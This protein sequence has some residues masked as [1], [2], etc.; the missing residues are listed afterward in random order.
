MKIVEVHIGEL[1]YKKMILNVKIYRKEIEMKRKIDKTI[2]VF[3][4]LGMIF[5]QL[6]SPLTVF[7]EVANEVIENDKEEITDTNALEDEVNNEIDNN[8][9]EKE[10]ANLEDTTIDKEESENSND[11]ETKEEEQIATVNNE[12]TNSETSSNYEQKEKQEQEQEQEQEH[13][14]EITTSEN[15]ELDTETGI[16]NLND[17]ENL[18]VILTPVVTT[19][20]GKIEAKLGEKAQEI[21]DSFNI[22]FKTRTSGIYNVTFN[23]YEEEQLKDSI[24]IIIN[25]DLASL[26]DDYLTENNNMGM[27]FNSKQG[28]ITGLYGST[29]NRITTIA[30]VLNEINRVLQSTDE[31][32]DT[33]S[34]YTGFEI[35]LNY[36][37]ESFEY[38]LVALGDIDT[39][40]VTDSDIQSILDYSI[41]RKILNELETIA[42][43]VNKDG[44]TDILDVTNTI[45]A[46][47]TDSFE[48]ENTNEDNYSINLNSNNSVKENDRITLNLDISGFNLGSINGI[49]GVLNYDSNILE[50]KGAN[51]EQFNFGTLNLDNNKFAFAG[52]NPINSNSTIITFTFK[53]IASG[54]VTVSVSDVKLANNGALLSILSNTTSNNITVEPILSDDNN[55]NSITISSGTI[56]KEINNEDTYYIINVD[57]SVNTITINGIL[58]SEKASSEGFGT[59]NLTGTH[60]LITVDVTAEDGTAKKYTFEV[61]KNIDNTNN[62]TNT[63]NQ[64]NKETKVETV[65]L[66]KFIYSSDS[67]LENLIIEGYEIEFD[68]DTYEYSL[69][70]DS[71]VE[72]LILDPILSNSNATYTIYGN[73]DFQ[74]GENIVTIVVTAEDGSTST[75]KINVNKE[76]K[77]EIKTEDKEESKEEN[78]TVKTVIIIIIILVII[79]LVYLIF[80][81]DDEDKNEEYKPRNNNSNKKDNKNRK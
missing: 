45:K 37:E 5:S 64:N 60:T 78:S 75:Y 50:L 48:V 36:M 13:L 58:S 65:S 55:I 21:T 80:K 35:V 56:N 14:I 57:S 47:Q 38:K 76:E 49:E 17:I 31:S 28:T 44:V 62:T 63:N 34:I 11:S 7:A 30:S 23:L 77:K 73:S 67:Y 69:T 16:Y 4:A 3:F 71:D 27:I 61:I 81:D 68:K 42:S 33:N 22:D 10:N 6:Y 20:T 66:Q 15:I 46:V 59:Y 32:T 1:G 18:N 8:N 72:S 19:T 51:S 79:G 25:Y 2:K 24:T 74:E 54:N 29:T 26:L 53:A 70:V 43:D 39:G 41:G 52:K 12:N 9:L 40:Y